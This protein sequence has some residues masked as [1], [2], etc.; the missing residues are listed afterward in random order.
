[1]L[2]SRPKG[3]TDTLFFKEN[4]HWIRTDPVTLGIIAVS[5]A[6]VGLGVEAY[7]MLTQPKTPTASAAPAAPSTDDAS[8]AAQAA[9]T[10]DRR[11]LLA[12]GGATTLTGIGGAPILS[13]DTAS[14]SLLGG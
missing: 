14:K 6:G 1:M 5:M 9:L 12:S 3:F 2:P 8:A 7:S 11:A 10:K 13:G 4:R